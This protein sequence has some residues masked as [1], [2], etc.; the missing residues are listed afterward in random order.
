MAEPD[1]Q[2][3][4]EHTSAVA[5]AA[6]VCLALP[7][8]VV[9]VYDVVVAIPTTA[10]S[11][12][13]HDQVVSFW[14]DVAGERRARCIPLVWLG[15]GALL[16]ALL[17]LLHVSPYR[18]LGYVGFVS[19]AWF[20][21]ALYGVIS[22]P[23]PGWLHGLV[24]GIVVGAIARVRR[25]IRQDIEMLVLLAAVLIGAGIAWVFIS[26][27]RPFT[28]AGYFVLLGSAVLVVIAW[29]RLFRPVVETVL[30]IAV[31]WS[32]RISGHGPGLDDFP[33]TGPCIVMANHAAWF[34]PLFLAKYVPRPITPMMTSRFFDLPIMRQLMI[35]FGTI[36]VSERA[37]KKETP[38]IQKAIE[39]LDRGECLVIFPEG[40]LRRTEEQPLRRFGQGIWQ[41]LQARPN[42][43]VYACWIEGGWGSYTS[44]YNGPPTKNKRRDFRRPMSVGVEPASVV[45]PAVLADQMETR[46]YLMNQVSAAR[47]N[48]GLQPLPVFQ[49]PP[50]SESAE[51]KHSTP[52]G[53]S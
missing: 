23:W 43:P 5:V 26:R 50:K 35:S 48:L 46:Y 21:A 28:L 47:K 45:P 6:L 17:S 36:S 3:R 39:A 31:L 10:A 33:R 13:E 11:V 41:I 53:G 18:V 14:N 30:E 25:G 32:Y 51:N 12:S 4:W 37:L 49:L 16:G 34:D 52:E 9:L 29:S 40:Y 8:V 22:G 24:L 27:G 42:V 19:V 15:G 44:Y 7:T 1:P 2:V 38:E 20:G